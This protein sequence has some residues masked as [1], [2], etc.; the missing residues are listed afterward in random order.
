MSADP[1][2]TIEAAL[3][4]IRRRI[5]NPMDCTK[6]QAIEDAVALLNAFSLAIKPHTER[7]DG[8]CDGCRPGA[9]WPCAVVRGSAL[10]LA[11]VRREAR[12]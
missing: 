1:W 10:V 12:T 7:A 9:S 11:G 6:N 3:D 5:N 4:A 2:E 8:E